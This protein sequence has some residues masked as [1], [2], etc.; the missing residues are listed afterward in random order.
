MR[1]GVIAFYEIIF[2]AN[3]K[4]DS[5]CQSVRPFEVLFGHKAYRQLGRNKIALKRGS[6]TI[7]TAG[8]CQRKLLLIL[9][10]QQEMGLCRK[11]DGAKEEYGLQL[12]EPWRYLTGFKY[13]QMQAHMQNTN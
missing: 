7:I 4:T 10:D 12:N 11:W 6:G 5:D 13:H 9:G 8:K 1:F 3:C 2:A